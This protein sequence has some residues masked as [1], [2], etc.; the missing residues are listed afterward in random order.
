MP[1][2][3]IDP[4][5]LGEMAEAI[6]WSEER[7]PGLGDELLVAFDEAI[8]RAAALGPSCR[9]ALGAPRELGAMRV[10]VRRFP[11]VVIFMVRPVA[12]AEN[13]ATSDVADDHEIHVLA[14]AHG[15]R[16]PGYW[17]TRTG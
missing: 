6:A 16:R 12:P 3:T 15:R 17:R 11:Y 7:G 1:A 9:P 10:L 8:Q 2:I 4:D 14:V 5:A 13:V